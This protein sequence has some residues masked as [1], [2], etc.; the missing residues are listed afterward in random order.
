MEGQTDGEICCVERHSGQ[1]GIERRLQLSGLKNATVNFYPPTHAKGKKII[2]TG[3]APE[4]T[5]KSLPY[6]ITEAGRCLTIHNITGEL[7]ISW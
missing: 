2:M 1:V 7:L 3:T 6:E 5:A 4:Q